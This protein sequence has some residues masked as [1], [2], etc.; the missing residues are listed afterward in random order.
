[1]LK[2]GLVLA[3]L[4][5][6]LSIA[7]SGAASL[8]GTTCTAV[9]TVKAQG[10]TRFKCTKVGAK[11]IWRKLPP[12]GNPSQPRP[13]PTAST[14]VPTVCSRDAVS[15][16]IGRFRIQLVLADPFD[17][18][19]PLHGGGLFIRGIGT[20][21]Q[22]MSADI[23]GRVGLSL[24]S[25]TYEIST[26]GL[27][28][29]DYYFTRLTYQLSVQ[30]NGRYSVNSNLQVGDTCAV[31][32]GLSE[33]ARARL[34]QL[35]SSTY[36][37]PM[38]S[39]QRVEPTET[40]T[41]IAPI[42]NTS[43][44]VVSFPVHVWEGRRLVLLSLSP[45]HDSVTVGRY[46][47]SL[48]AAIEIY[49]TVTNGY[50]PSTR[51]IWSRTFH[52][53]P[54]LAQIPEHVGISCGGNACTAPGTHGIEMRWRPLESALWLIQRFDVYEMTA[55]YELGR[56]YWNWQLCSPPLVWHPDDA[57]V[58]GYAVLM[59][60][61]TMDALKLEQGPEGQLSGAAWRQTTLNAESV[62][63]N[64][65]SLTLKD[66]L[67]NP[68]VSRDWQVQRPLGN[69]S[70]VDLWASVMHYLGASH[71]GI[72]FYRDFFSNCGRLPSARTSSEAMQN[73]IT[74]SSI[75]AGRDLTAVF[76]DRWKLS[77]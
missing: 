64:S 40:T 11:R 2:R 26:V 48:E 49:E 23:G 21:W 63:A 3:L 57:T 54:V 32:I 19:V 60:F 69:L 70:R 62:V 34:S 6:L 8:A 7:P 4:T 43:E 74:L 1:M 24:Q 14:P 67:F 68:V 76:R 35:K 72:E 25:G 39:A 41:Y 12:A 44:K 46:L 53:K 33:G 15:D 38:A 71:G 36:I 47:T 5:S 52:G 20:E 17:S 51:S 65:P 45:D 31:T 18:R 73:W 50:A 27:E 66:L 42:S 29:T 59:R 56:S 22:Y 9:G 37:S 13:V 28:R 16:G 61:V 77:L 58:T 10:T 55:F 75:A 30:A